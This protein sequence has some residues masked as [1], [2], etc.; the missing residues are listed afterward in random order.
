M[1]VVMVADMVTFCY[2]CGIHGQFWRMVILIPL[3]DS[4]DYSEDKHSKDETEHQCK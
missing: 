2:D 1:I 3:A 4:F